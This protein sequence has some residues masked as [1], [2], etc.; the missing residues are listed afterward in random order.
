[1]RTLLISAVL[2]IAVA[3]GAISSAAAAGADPVVGTWQ[4]NVSKSTFTAGQALKSQTRTF[5][6]STGSRRGWRGG[7]LAVRRIG[8][9]LGR[10]ICSGPG[11]SLPSSGFNQRV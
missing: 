2:A 1:M 11:R 8:R 5:W 9:S 4:L 7:R 3:A 6:C 10:P